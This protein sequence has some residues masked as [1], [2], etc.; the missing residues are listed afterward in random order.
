M[1]LSSTGIRNIRIYMLQE[2]GLV[3][4]QSQNEDVC[5]RF[6]VPYLGLL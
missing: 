1:S 6:Y 4:I 3:S 2:W 5:V